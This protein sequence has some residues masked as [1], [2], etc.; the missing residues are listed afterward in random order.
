MRL[1]AMDKFCIK[2]R[3]LLYKYWDLFVKTTLRN[4]RTEFCHSPSATWTMKF[5]K[6]NNIVRAVWLD[7]RCFFTSENDRTGKFV[8]FPPQIFWRET[9]FNLKIKMAAWFT[10]AVS[11]DNFISEQENKARTSQKTERDVKLLLYYTCF[12]K[13]IMKKEKWKLFRQQNWTSTRLSLSIGQNQRRERIYLLS[14]V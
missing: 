4:S 14:E 8:R 9:Y 7:E 1:Y 11:V 12:W 2:K 5:H 6:W 10:D 13:P 3:Y